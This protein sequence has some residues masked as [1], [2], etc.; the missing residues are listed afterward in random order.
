MDDDR[1]TTG[2]D[3]FLLSSL[4]RACPKLSV[5]AAQMPENVCS[6]QIALSAILQ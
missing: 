4:M 5:G 2:A 3:E 1:K 6:G